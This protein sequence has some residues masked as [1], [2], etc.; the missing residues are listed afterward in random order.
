MVDLLQNSIN[1]SK[2]RRKKVLKVKATRALSPW[3]M[4][5]LHGKL[6][7]KSVADISLGKFPVK[8]NS[9]GYVN[10]LGSNEAPIQRLYEGYICHLQDS[11]I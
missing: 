11:N 8:V 9:H 7:L 10:N 6:N 3:K 4:A 5:P 1:S 2:K